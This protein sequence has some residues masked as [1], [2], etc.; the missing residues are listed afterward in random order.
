MVIGTQASS[1]SCSPRRTRPKDVEERSRARGARVA[2]GGIVLSGAVQGLGLFLTLTLTLTLTSSD[3]HRHTSERRPRARH[4]APGPKTRVWG[5]R[6]V[7][8][9]VG[10]VVLSTAYVRAFFTIIKAGMGLLPF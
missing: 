4:G 8:R 10:L 6:R 1:A 5:E 3:G 2:S 7:P 9:R